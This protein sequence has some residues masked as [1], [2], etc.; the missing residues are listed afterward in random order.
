[1]LNI[2]QGRKEQGSVLHKNGVSGDATGWILL[3]DLKWDKTTLSALDLLVVVQRT[4]LRSLR[5]LRRRD[6]E[7]L[8]SVVSDVQRVVE[9]LYGS[10]SAACG[11]DG[12]GVD[13]DMLKFFV[14]CKSAIHRSFSVYAHGPFSRR[15]CIERTRNVN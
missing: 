6:V 13:G 4:D 5:D 1:M 15:A 3:P 10:A 11:R 12:E 8:R 14:H 7:W 2:L 9:R